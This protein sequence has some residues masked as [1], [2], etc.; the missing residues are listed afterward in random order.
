MALA[1]DAVVKARNTLQDYDEDRWSDEELLAEVNGARR[2]Y[3]VADPSA[4]SKSVVVSLV[5]GVEQQCPVDSNVFYEATATVD[6]S[7]N[8]K[9]AV[10]VAQ[11]E[12]LDTFV[13]GWRSAKGAETQH[14]MFSERSPNEFLVYP[15]AVAGAK[16]RLK[17][18]A[19]PAPI[20]LNATLSAQ[21][22]LQVDALADYAVARM[23][24]QDASSPVNQQRAV[25]HLQLFSAATGADFQSLLRSSPNSAN[26]GGRLPKAAT[27][28]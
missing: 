6:S 22:S 19:N 27:G 3:A 13:P 2:A 14:F 28:Q 21:E 18:S 10:T 9:K 12:Y 1:S 17:Y 5:D 8:D 23:L 16:V 7:G 25:M 24:L 26:V 20:G 11:R 15:R 4:Y